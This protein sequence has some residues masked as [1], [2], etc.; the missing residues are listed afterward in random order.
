MLSV[1]AVC[2]WGSA[3]RGRVHL[4]RGMDL[5]VMLDQNSAAVPTAVPACFSD[6]QHTEPH[7]G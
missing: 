6:T 7:V 5:W 3:R 4:R 1:F 2:K